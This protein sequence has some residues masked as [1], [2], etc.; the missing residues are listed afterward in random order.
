MGDALYILTKKYNCSYAERAKNFYKIYYKDFKNMDELQNLY[1]VAVDYKLKPKTAMYINISAEELWLKIVKI[2]ISLFIFYEEK[3]LKKKF[4]DFNC[5]FNYFLSNHSKGKLIQIVKTIFD[6]F[7]LDYSGKKKFRSIY[8]KHNESLCIL[9]S[10]S[11]LTCRRD[12]EIDQNVAKLIFNL[13]KK[14]KNM[15]NESDWNTITKNFLLLIHPSGEIE[16]AL[17]QKK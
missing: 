5:Y 9:Y 3:R 15:M 8:L 11:L 4:P 7:L 1:P 13:N 6:Y 2:Y 10:L 14:D 12:K 16:R 17:L